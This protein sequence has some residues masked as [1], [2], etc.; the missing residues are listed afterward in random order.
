MISEHKDSNSRKVSKLID[1]INWIDNPLGSTENWDANLK[2]MLSMVLA[3]PM[4]MSIVW[5]KELI[6][7]YNDSYAGIWGD[8]FH[9]RAYGSS[10]LNFF[11]KSREK[12]VTVFSSVF[13]GEAITFSDSVRKSPET[14]QFFD[15]TFSPLRDSKGVI[16]GILIT[17]VET[18]ERKI[19]EEKLQEN[20]DQL[21]FAIDAVDLGTWDYN[22]QT[23]EF[24][25]N[26]ILKSWFGLAPKDKIDLSFAVDAIVP[27]DRQRVI[28]AIQYSLLYESGGKYN[29]EYTIEN[30]LNGDKRIVR[31]KGKAWF[32]DDQIC[33]RLNGTLEDITLNTLARRKSAEKE[34]IV[35]NMVL[36]APVGICVI[37]AKSKVIEIVN[38]RFSEII[39][40]P[41]SF[42]IEKP[43]WEVLSE[44][45][46]DFSAHLEKVTQTGIPYFADEVELAL[47]HL[48][49]GK[50]VYAT[51]V[52]SPLTNEIGQISKIAIW[53]VDNTIQVRASKKVIESEYNLSLMILQ[54]PI[55]ITILRG[56][57][58][59]VEIANKNVLGLW[60]SKEEDVVGRS[61]FEIMPSLKSQGL[62][63]L[64]DH[65]RRKRKRFSMAEYPMQVVRNGELETVYINFSLEP[66]YDEESE[67]TG[68][69]AIGVD[70]TQQVLNRKVIEE[71]EQR[72]RSI[73]ENAPF[74]IGVYEG[75]D[76]MIT[77]ANHAIMDVWG[78][79][80]DVV[81][82]SYKSILPELANQEIFEQI[83]NVFA[84]GIPFS[85]KN[86]RVDLV[87]DGHL[88]SFFFNYDFTPLYNTAGEI[89]GV[90]NTAA[91]VTDIHIAKLKVEES[92]KRFRDSVEQAPLGIAIFRGKDY[93]VE[94]ANE[95]YLLLID[96]TEESFISKPIFKVLPEVRETVEPIFEQVV[97]TGIPFFGNDFPVTLKRH[98]KLELT[99]FNFVYHPLKEESG[100]I[101]GIMV[102]AM[103][104]TE[105]VKAKQLLQ[106][107]EKH[108]RNM[109]MQSPIP[110]TILRGKDFIIESAN[111]VMFE[112]VW[113][114]K[115]EGVIGR[116]I[117]DIFPELRVQKYPELLNQVFTTGKTHS[118]KESMAIVEGEDG[119]KKFFLDFEYAA[120]HDAD[121][122]VSGIMITVSDVTDKVEARQK[123]EENEE[124]LNIVV[125]ASELG[126]WEYD[127]K[128]D[129]S[130]ISPRC[131]EIFGFLNGEE[132]STTAMMEVFHPEE[133]EQINKAYEEAYKSGT[134]YYETRLI[135]KDKSIHWVEVR[136]KGF[137]DEAGNPERLV[138]T[139]RDVTEEK[140]FHKQLLEREEKFR[141]LADS[142]PQMVWTSDSDGVL[143]YYNKALYDFTGLSF[144]ELRG[145]GW[146][147]VVHPD[148]RAENIEKWN[149]SI[150]TGEDY[151]FEHRFRK[152]DGTYRWQLSRA[153]P[154]R[155]EQGNIR[156]WVGSSTDIQD[157][158]VFTQELENKVIDRTRELNL[159]NSDLEK[160]NKELQSFAYISSHDLQEPLRKIQTFT[161]MI[162]EEEYANMTQRGKDMFNRMQGAAVR[163]QTLIQD[164]LAY[165]RTNSQERNFVFSNLQ[166]ILDEVKNDLKEEVDNKG[167]EVEVVADCS[168]KVIPFQFRQLLF[169][170]F[171]NS[172]KFIDS[173]K[174]P[175]IKIT[176]EQV[177]GR[178]TGIE[179]LDSDKTYSHITFSDN[180]IGFDSAYKEKIFEVFQR[181]HGKTEYAGTGI[182]LAIVK[183][184]VDNHYG[185]IKAEGKSGEGARFDIYI[186]V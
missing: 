69:M 99:Y 90:M 77:L 37:G 135:W 26:S 168:V 178:K 42:M 184:I 52:F 153:I 96:K 95:K 8:D 163:M 151:H 87:I 104:V 5:G 68:V 138:G 27:E 182:G 4:A 115:P 114:R 165:S 186:P 22:P 62:K 112:S 167:A 179:G 67:G 110:M 128:N 19:I 81:G 80:N 160:I 7:L 172:L 101:S 45:K 6:L 59:M 162:L 122:S 32:R 74:P 125:T 38:Q 127:V 181:L 94:M 166:T 124:R 9:P 12:W 34:Q 131:N 98:G 70:V 150:S 10:A 43:F 93:V 145:D 107:S 154:Q 1:E 100:A 121:G 129:Q 71:S 85:A 103:E 17:A 102:V 142:M 83:Y 56:L 16:Q 46:V 30:P 140:N 97:A 28:D 152:F 60:G 123:I 108:F 111:K 64:L 134:L 109:V 82:K 2:A 79:G 136:G 58:Y 14:E 118:E 173:S 133:M 144:E 176:C 171:S 183:K 78:K 141:L 49:V 65:V 31:A 66:L 185:V 11:G 33:Y 25:A 47:D 91:E 36:E 157:Q 75:Q 76:L 180:G 61:I 41:S 126:V 161:S 146:I 40:K 54:A 148:D 139:I 116:S 18:T 55:S 149:K 177:S 169:N 88:Q 73:V 29:I 23:N 35:R 51:L 147:Q 15:F 174:K 106:E 86:Q 72:I 84:T 119:I 92:E 164:L 39:G 53:I 24:I 44:I 130:I 155:D 48:G 50:T 57:D 137:F 113:R 159:K 158:R 105:T 89:Y 120:L 63:K 132:I 20:T 170:L 156:M 21:H 13:K 3:N 143:N 117:L 175:L